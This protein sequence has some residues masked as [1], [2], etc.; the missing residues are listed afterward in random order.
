MPDTAFDDLKSLE[1]V[2]GIYHHP[3][4]AAGESALRHVPL[5]V[6]AFIAL[7]RLEFTNHETDS[8]TAD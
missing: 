5:P 1:S 3:A 8:I 2:V 4:D 6:P 7:Q